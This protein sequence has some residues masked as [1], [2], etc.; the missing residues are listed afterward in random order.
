MEI[1]WQRQNSHRRASHLKACDL[2]GC[3]ASIPCPFIFIHSFI[4]IF[5]ELLLSDTVL[6]I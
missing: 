2:E 5:V 3:Y 6:D 4:L 1:E